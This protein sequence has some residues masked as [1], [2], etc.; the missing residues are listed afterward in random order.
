MKKV[1]SAEYLFEFGRGA[2]ES[3]KHQNSD[4]DGDTESSMQD[5]V[6]RSRPSHFQATAN[7]QIATVEQKMAIRMH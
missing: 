6:F 3:S 4:E 7:R 2:A 1:K 5:Q